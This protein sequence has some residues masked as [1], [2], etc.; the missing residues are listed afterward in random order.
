MITKIHSIRGVG[1]FNDFRPIRPIELG[2][3]NLI[4]SENGLGKSTIAD[5][6]RSMN[7][8]EGGR[9]HARETIGSRVQEIILETSAGTILQYGRDGWNQYLG[10]ILVFDEIFIDE[11]IYSGLNVELQQQ[12][13]LF[14]VILGDVSVSLV[15]EEQKLKR[16]IE[17][18]N[19]K[20]RELKK[21]IVSAIYEPSSQPS[22]DM[23]FTSFLDLP[24]VDNIER[25]LEQQTQLLAQ[26][27][28]TERIQNAATFAEICLPQLPIKELIALMATS[29]DDVESDA[30]A[31]FSTHLDKFQMTNK[32]R[33]WIEEG[34]HFCLSDNDTCPYC[35]QSLS[36]SEVVRQYQGVFSREYKRLKSEIAAF[37]SKLA[38][39]DNSLNVIHDVIVANQ[40]QWD[41]L[42]G[43]IKD[44]ELPEL[45][46]HYI[47]TICQAVRSEIN[48]LL[49][50]KA[51]APLEKMPLSDELQHELA[52]WNCL[53]LSLA[54]YNEQVDRNNFAIGRLKTDLT[55]SNIAAER[56]KLIELTNIKIRYSRDI[57][58]VCD[59]YLREVG[60][61]E[62]EK[63]QVKSLQRTMKSNIAQTFRERSF[64][65]NQYLSR[66]NAGFQIR[67]MAHQSTGGRWKTNYSLALLGKKI[68]MRTSKT[69][70]GT[71]THKQVLSE[72]D[73]RALAFAFFM[74]ILHKDRELQQNIIVFDDPA[75]SMD[76]GRMNVVE[77]CILEI[78]AYFRQVIVLSHRRD[79]LNALWK[80]NQAQFNGQDVTALFSIQ[81][82]EG[83]PQFSEICERILD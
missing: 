25:K 57:P 24:Q 81:P 59:S 83:H 22:V 23:A 49:D 75:T 65:L 30:E 12:R 42:K 56:Y 43:L 79:F 36:P 17:S 8:N 11:N 28:N 51:A 50:A 34:A 61:R 64:T 16:S 80:T 2:K 13:N 77:E 41:S 60:L 38:D 19:K 55:T 70:A 62:S 15:E 47:R 46:F 10:G 21:I 53:E 7:Q 1:R 29:I 63:A 18:R 52:C 6:F 67:D 31:R 26:L 44:L 54:E 39:I 20:I 78:S 76:E 37:P 35:G 69:R 40:R 3:L 71:L 5:L 33:S 27:E 82:M 58:S 9:L 68:P 66:F 32:L 74:S 4:Y 45:D 72:G 14:P 48:H 73:R